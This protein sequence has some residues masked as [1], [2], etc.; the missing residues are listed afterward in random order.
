[1]P[2]KKGFTGVLAC[3]THDIELHD[4]A[5]N[6]ANRSEWIENVL[7]LAMRTEQQRKVNMVDAAQAKK[8][9]ES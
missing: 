1:M 7:W 9:Q 4:Y 2:R 3:R 5:R 6:K 8:L